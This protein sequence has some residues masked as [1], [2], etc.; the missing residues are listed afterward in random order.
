MRHK[1]QILDFL[2]TVLP[3][4]RTIEIQPIFKTGWILDF[5]TTTYA[6]R[7]QQFSICTCSNA[8]CALSGMSNTNTTLKEFIL[9]KCFCYFNTTLHL[10][11]CSSIYLPFA[12]PIF[13]FVWLSWVQMMPG[14]RDAKHPLGLQ[15]SQTE[16]RS[17]GAKEKRKWQTRAQGILRATKNSTGKRRGECRGSLEAQWWGK[18]RLGY[19]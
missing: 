8:L 18:R 15:Q 12:V 16:G 3:E 7:L 14:C 11:L 9:S 4:A 5:N 17:G 13:L 2:F 10:F 6:Q 19:F 1:L